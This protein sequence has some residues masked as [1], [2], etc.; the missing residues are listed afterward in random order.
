MLNLE[1][2]ELLHQIHSGVKKYSELKNLYGYKSVASVQTILRPLVSDN[3]LYRNDK[4]V[5]MVNE[6]KLEETFKDLIV[7]INWFRKNY[8]TIKQKI[9]RV[10][11]LNK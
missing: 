1:K 4:N 2:L 10:K 9:T 8:K 5:L 7:Y 11:K 6:R 3:Y